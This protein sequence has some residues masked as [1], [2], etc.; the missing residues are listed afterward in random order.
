ML[1]Q[2]WYAC[3]M[4]MVTLLCLESAHQ[5]QFLGSSFGITFLTNSLKEITTFGPI[6]TQSKNK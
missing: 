1:T 5:L 2:S 6:K 4:A 3:C